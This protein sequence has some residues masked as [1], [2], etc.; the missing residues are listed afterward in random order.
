MVGGNQIHRVCALGEQ[1]DIPIVLSRTVIDDMEKAVKGSAPALE[2]ERSKLF[3][4]KELPFA[5][6]QLQIS[7]REYLRYL[8]S[9]HVSVKPRGFQIVPVDNPLFQF[10]VNAQ[11]Y[12][13]NGTTYINGRE[14]SL[15]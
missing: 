9:L 3:I 6:I 7:V 8:N 2:T 10:V 4:S 1:M 5:A 11:T 15:I 12:I 13:E 14:V